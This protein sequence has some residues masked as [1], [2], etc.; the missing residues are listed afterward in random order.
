L[1]HREPFLAI[2]DEAKNQGLAVAGHVP[3]FVSV[4]EASDAGLACMEH[5]Y[6]VLPA[7]SRLEA[8]LRKEL[9]ETMLKQD[10]PA[11]AVYA[12][13]SAQ[14]RQLLETYSDER[15]KELFARLAMNVTWQCPTLTV[16]RALGYLDDPEFTNDSR[17]KYVPPRRR[18]GWKPEND[19]RLKAWT[20]EDYAQQRMRF[21]KE[22]EL[23]GDMHRSGVPIL[24][25]TDAG[26]PYCFQGFSLHDELQLL[27]KAG[28]TPL[29]ALQTAT[30]NPA[31][32]L[33]RE[34][35]LGTI[36][37]GKLADLVLLI[38][39]PLKDIKNTNKIASVILGGKL[40]TRME[41]DKMLADV[42][43]EAGKN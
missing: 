33:E 22:L 35:D 39:D 13:R 25:G 9:T 42:E 20:P 21:N 11:S 34:K 12:I 29:Q 8:E 43:A 7:C 14:T 40:L 17:L 27:V 5:L 31:R 15:A 30:L 18:E 36:E 24:A 32:F 6:G 19:F 26:N 2:V 10:V 4:V 41:L 38:A 37:V 28:L 23:L 16:L 1:L 3:E